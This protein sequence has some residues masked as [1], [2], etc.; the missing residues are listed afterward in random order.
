MH[1]LT[2]AKEFSLTKKNGMVVYCPSVDHLLWEKV[3][4]WEDFPIK[5]A[6]PPTPYIAYQLLLSSTSIWLFLSFV[7]NWKVSHGLFIPIY[8]LLLTSSTR[9]QLVHPSSFSSAAYFSSVALLISGESFWWK[10]VCGWVLAR[11]TSATGEPTKV[12]WEWSM[13]SGAVVVWSEGSINNKDDTSGP[14]SHPPLSSSFLLLFPKN[15]PYL[16]IHYMKQSCSRVAGTRQR[17]E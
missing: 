16:W 15:G 11:V 8:L 10:W 2:I 3:A 14:I 4:I 13:Q 7:F 5:S 17:V 6:Y 1:S 12:F 9:L